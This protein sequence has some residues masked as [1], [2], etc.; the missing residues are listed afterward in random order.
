MKYEFLEHTAD[1][2]FRAYGKSLD[3]CFENVILAFSEIIAKGNKINSTETKSI[4]VK[5]IDKKSLFYKF[6]EELNYLVGGGFVVCSGKVVV[7]GNSLKARLNGDSAENY[8]GLGEVKAATYAEMR[9]SKKSA[10]RW[11]VQAVLDV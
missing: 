7:K 3:E 5:G 11:L 9:I 8:R 1:V 6:L 2:K 10:N 4:S